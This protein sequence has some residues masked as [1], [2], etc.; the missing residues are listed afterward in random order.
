MSST[1]ARVSVCICTYR[2]PQQ[3]AWLLADLGAQTRRPDEV[4]VVDNE[5]EGGGRASVEAART[6]APFP[7]R[8]E[9]QPVKNISR[10]R[11]RAVALAEGDWLALLDDDE[12]APAHWLQT[13]LDTAARYQADGVIAPVV[14]V[15]PDSAPDWIRRGRFYQPARDTPT[16]EIMPL[17]SVG[18]GN[19]L[20]HGARLRALE[21]PFDEAY[22]LTGGEDSDLLTRLVQGG[23]RLVACQEA[24]V[25]EPVV[26]VRLNLRW[27][28]LRAVRGNQDYARNWR[29]GRFGALRPWSLPVF[30]LRAALQLGVAALLTPLSL[31]LGRHRAARWLQT[32]AGNF[33]KLS[34][35]WGWHYQEYAPPS[36]NP[37]PRR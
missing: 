34:T 10:T 27:I 33:G 7:I 17:N 3:L 15:V 19:A 20:L 8:Y 24:A 25:T 11:N 22:G 35:L 31:P 26:A 4:V 32:A 13:L 9:I 23:A 2:R 18:I 6:G 12:R 30:Y 28:L 29:R 5:A 37:A 16:G 36:A 1:L 21:G 14:S